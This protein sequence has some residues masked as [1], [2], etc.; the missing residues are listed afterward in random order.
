MSQLSRDPTRSRY[1]R[2]GD[3]NAAAWSLGA[4]GV[5]II[6]VFAYFGVGGPYRSPAAP[7]APIVQAAPL[8]GA[9]DVSL[10]ET[11]GQ[12]APRAP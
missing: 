9:P 7:N 8:V 12:T 3:N 4:V 5:F 10:I 1:A 2:P 11:T 6:L